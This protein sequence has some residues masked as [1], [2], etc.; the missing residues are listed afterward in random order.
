MLLDLNENKRKLSDNLLAA[1]D[2]LLSSGRN[3][4]LT[5]NSAR[6]YK[7]RGVKRF[8][9]KKLSL[10]SLLVFPLILHTGNASSRLT[11]AINSSTG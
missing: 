1:G 2:S 4:T 7:T 8:V 5:K 11:E 3:L 10:L 9:L 6:E